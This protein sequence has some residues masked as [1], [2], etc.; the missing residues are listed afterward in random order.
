LRSVDCFS[1]LIESVDPVPEC[2]AILDDILRVRRPQQ[3]PPAASARKRTTG[4]SRGARGIMTSRYNR[5][6]RA[7]SRDKFEVI[8]S[9]LAAYGDFDCVADVTRI[10]DF[11]GLSGTLYVS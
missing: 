9:R 1:K 6:I 11:S 2:D 10:P 5:G 3:E 4:Y 8:F 7:V